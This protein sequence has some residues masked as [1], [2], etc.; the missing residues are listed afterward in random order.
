MNDDRD[1]DAKKWEYE[2]N[3]SMAEKQHDD[4]NEFFF[5]VNEATINNG[6]LALRTLVLING[7]AAVAILAFVGSLVTTNG[8]KFSNHLTQLTSPLMW[9]AWGVALA[10]IGIGLA[11]AANYSTVSHASSKSRHY[12]HPFVRDTPASNRWMIAVYTFQALAILVAIGS[13]AMF[14]YGMYDIR[15]AITDPGLLSEA[16]ASL[17]RG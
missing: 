3:R 4:E 8:E 5:R 10:A 11:Y 7:G 13:L 9:F 14:I 12:E 15:S 2:Q 1:W 17:R 16:A 6:N